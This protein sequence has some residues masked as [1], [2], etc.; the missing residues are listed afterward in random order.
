GGFVWDWQ[1]KSLP[2]PQSDGHVGFAHGGDFGERFIESREPVYMTNN[3]LVRAD[4]SWIPVA[5]VVREAYAPILIDR[6][7]ALKDNVW[8]ALRDAC[9]F[10]AVNRTLCESSLDYRLE[11][12]AVDGRGET[13]RRCPVDLPALEPGESAALELSD[14]LSGL[15]DAAPFYLT[16]RVFRRR[17]GEEVASRQFR[18]RD[19]VKPLPRPKAGPLPELTRVGRTLR[20][21]AGGTEAVF[22]C[23]TGMLL[24]LSRGDISR[25]IASKLCWDR[26]YTGL[27]AQKGWGIRDHLDAVRSMSMAHAPAEVFQSADC[28]MVTSAFAGEFAAGRIS[29]TLYGGGVI[30][31]ALD[32]KAGDG[33][34]LPRFGVEFEL[35]Q[36]ME[37]VSY[38]GLGPMENYADRVLSPAFGRYACQMDELGFDYAPPSENGGHGGTEELCLCDAAGH[39]LLARAGKAFHFDARRCTVEDLQRALHTAEVPRRDRVY[40]HLDAWHMPIGGDMAWSTT[41][42]AASLP[43]GG[44]HTLRVRLSAENRA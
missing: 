4:L 6:P 41:L 23:D 36:E 31:C 8:L 33:A 38:L 19:A 39:M 12:S 14:A 26:P 44:I 34:I 25:I 42:D 40:L 3:G 20:F 1:D 24:S 22:S 27:D 5:W 16:F 32:V 18:C 30:D 13:L 2:L 7:L 35:P 21:R 17:D 37:R 9:G 11:V 29:W 10:V 28:W 15:E 43:Q